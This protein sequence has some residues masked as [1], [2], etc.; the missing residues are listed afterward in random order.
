[1]AASPQPR[2]GNRWLRG[3]IR[4]PAFQPESPFRRCES[5]G[6]TDPNDLWWSAWARV[7]N[8]GYYIGQ[9]KTPYQGAI[10]RAS[11]S[12]SGSLI[13]YDPATRTCPEA[14]PRM[15]VV[16][17][18]PNVSSPALSP[19]KLTFSKG[20]Q[21]PCPGPGAFVGPFYDGAVHVMGP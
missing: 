8:Q 1:M 17:G 11:N 15:V 3:D 13:A 6:R 10:V 14:T 12:T 20:T 19:R 18:A 21:G 5:P 2:G 16:Y 4:K 7:D 9:L